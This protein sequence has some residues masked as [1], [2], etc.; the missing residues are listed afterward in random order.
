MAARDG[1]AN[2]V[3]N[4]GSSVE[5]TALM[6]TRATATPLASEWEEV[7]VIAI[8]TL[9]AEKAAGEIAAAKAVAQGGFAGRIQWPKVFR[10]IRLEACGERFERIVEA[11]PE[12]RAAC[13]TWPVAARHASYTMDVCSLIKV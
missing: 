6:A 13:T 5:S 2:F 9:H 12:W 1:Q 8:R 4:E 7:V 3:A 10:A 11:L